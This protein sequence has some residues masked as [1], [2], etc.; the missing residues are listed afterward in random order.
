MDI[1]FLDEGGAN[2]KTVSYDNNLNE[3]SAEIS[4]YE[5]EPSLSV[6][7]E[8]KET[9]YSKISHWILIVGVLVLPLFFL[10]WS[11]SILEFNKQMLLLVLAGTVLIL[12]LLHV[13]TSGQLSWRANPLDKG[14]LA[15]LS[16][17]SFSTVP[18]FLCL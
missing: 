1:N 2:I 9:I 16:A 13:V 5:Q 11:T 6:V 17:V 4:V 7:H 10:P 18:V 15:L 8:V 14:V 12:W 3:T